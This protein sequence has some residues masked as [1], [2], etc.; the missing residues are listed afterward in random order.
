MP[1]NN[2]D[3]IPVLEGTA[4]NGQIG[5]TIGINFIKKP[6]TVGPRMRPWGQG[7]PGVLS[8]APQQRLSP[9]GEAAHKVSE[10]EVPTPGGGS[11]ELLHSDLATWS[12]PCCHRRCSRGSSWALPFCPVGL[13]GF[14]PQAV[15]ATLH[16]RYKGTT[17]VLPGPQGWL[18]N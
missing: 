12:P 18:R 16:L 2:K 4:G 10:A 1:I 17:E 7:L 13:A 8:L 9:S 11:P 6:Y 5:T 15:S 3:M 14:S